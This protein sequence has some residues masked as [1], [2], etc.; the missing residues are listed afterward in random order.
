MVAKSD[1]LSY[2][3]PGVFGVSLRGRLA[4]CYTEGYREKD[5]LGGEDQSAKEAALKWMTNV[6][7]HA[8]SERSL[9]R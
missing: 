5:P 9:A 6:V 7:I 2:G 8:L 4:I 3:E 1:Q